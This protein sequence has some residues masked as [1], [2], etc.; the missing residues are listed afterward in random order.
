[1]PEI[2][3][4]DRYPRARRP[5]VARGKLKLARGGRLSVGD[6][7]SRTTEDLMMEHTLLQTARRFGRE[8]FDGD[9][10]YGYGGYYYDPKF[11]TPTA[12]RLHEHYQLRVGASVL[13]V[14]C[15]KGFLLHD[16]K[17]LYPDLTVAGIDISSYAVE[18][19]TPE[20]KPF[21]RV[22]DAVKLPYADKSFDLVVSINTVSNPSLEQCKQAIREVM[23]VSR[24]HAFITVHAWRTE[25]QRENL[26]MWNLTAQTSMHVSDWEQ[27]FAEVG[28][29]GDY[30]FWFAE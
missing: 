23:R 2:N 26:Q 1:M 19:G 6:T 17:R 24:A 21:L 13:D 14:G 5:I 3:L 20:I 7:G 27:V 30:Y 22:G 29:T 9:R 10:L 4:M 25:E 28:Y 18:R 15:A 16:L 11:W 8:Y 12:R